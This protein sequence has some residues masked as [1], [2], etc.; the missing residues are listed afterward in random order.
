MSVHREV[1]PEQKGEGC[2]KCLS[3]FAHIDILTIP[4]PH[5]FAATPPHDRDSLDASSP[6]RLRVERIAVVRLSLTLASGLPSTRLEANTSGIS[7]L[8]RIVSQ[9]S[10]PWRNNQLTVPV[11]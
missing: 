10:R 11:E 5:A 3:G 7:A 1:V 6:D 2:S 8:C 4:T 9:F